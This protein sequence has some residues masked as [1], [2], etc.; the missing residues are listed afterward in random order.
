MGDEQKPT[1]STDGIHLGDVVLRPVPSLGTDG[2]LVLAVVA[3]PDVA[4]AVA[5]LLAMG[6]SLP[7][8][9]PRV[10]A[11]LRGVLAQRL[12]P[13]RDGTGEILACEVMVTSGPVREAMRR[14]SAEMAAALRDQMEKGASPQGMATFD[15]AVRQLAAQGLVAKASG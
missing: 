13:R 11:S 14:D 15:M 7:D 10:T 2:H 9:A 1:L 5:R 3:A 4:R 6:R 8:I 12:L